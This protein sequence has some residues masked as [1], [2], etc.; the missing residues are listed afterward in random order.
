V[1]APEPLSERV[2]ADDT[3]DPMT[4]DRERW[5]ALTRGWLFPIGLFTQ[6]HEQQVAADEWSEWI[7][8]E[9]RESD[10]SNETF[11]WCEPTLT[12]GTEGSAKPLAVIVA[13][14]NAVP[15]LLA[16]VDR[17]RAITDAAERWGAATTELAKSEGE[18]AAANRKRSSERALARRIA[19][20]SKLDRRDRLRF[21]E[22]ALLAALADPVR[23]PEPE[24]DGE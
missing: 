6:R 7:E 4:F 10:P 2:V 8:Y 22:N 19:F 23:L 3:G 12:G 9:I 20:D 24:K 13:A 21:A 1:S 11:P 18:M 16:E 15:V 17:L 5:D 14:L